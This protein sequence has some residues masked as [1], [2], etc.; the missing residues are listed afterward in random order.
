MPTGTLRV[1]LLW[2]MHQPYYKNLVTGEYRLPWVRLHASKDYYGMVKLLDEFPQVHQNFNLVPSLIAQIE[3]YASGVFREPFYEVAAKPASELSP[4]EKRFALS[5]LFQANVSQM[6]GRYPRFRDLYERFKGAGEDPARAESSFTTRDYTDLQVL[7]QLAWL[8]EFWLA[9]PDVKELVNKREGY[10]AQDQKFVLQ[11]QREIIRAVLPAYRDAAARGSIEISPTPYYHPILPL[12]CDTNVGA[13]SSPGLP[14]PQNRFEHPDDADE[15]IRR[16]LNSH[17]KLFGVRPRG[18]WPSEGSVSEEV[19]AIASKNGLNWVATDEG[20]LGRSLDYN[21]NRDGDGRL[22]S[23]GAERLYKIYRYEKA[24]TKMHLVFRDHRISDLIGFVYANMAPRDA[25]S[26]LLRSLKQAAEPLLK[27]GSD[28]VVPIILDGENAWE[29]YHESGRDFLRY[30]YDSLSKDQGVQ[31]C[32]IS[33]AIA[34]SSPKQLGQLKSLVPGS[35]I[36][37]NFNVW[38]G[39][40]EDNRAW[41]YL[42]EA[43]EFYEEHADGATAEQRNLA[44]EELLIA[45][46]SDWNWWYGP[47]HHSANDRDFDDLYRA[48]LSNVYQALGGEPPDYLAQPIAAAGGRPTT[49]SQTAYISPRINGRVASY[50]DWMG[51]AMYAADRRTSS[52]HGKQFVLDA[53]YAGIND[54]S[55]SVRADLTQSL[56]AGS[57]EFRVNV[58]VERTNEKHGFRLD[59]I[60]TDG[61]MQRWSLIEENGAERQRAQSDGL[62]AGTQVAFQKILEAQIPF[63]LLGARANDRIKLRFSVWRDRL[64]IDALPLEGSVELAIVPEEAL[65]AGVYASR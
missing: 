14:L 12:V 16:A 51:A 20:V 58:D 32:T 56:E 4:E 40:K 61:K 9:Q 60:V 1:V 59:V 13:V 44:Y 33:E 7:S 23:D 21:F 45:E 15:Q 27:K 18:M 3:D 54:T 30:F 55:L 49:T 25:A 31:A 22:S 64:P 39:A 35:W 24:S 63:T 34:L 37:A 26:H 17:E 19:L 38:I 11:K 46:G 53:V 6:I 50:F 28:A 47:E 43:R 48:H 5:Y 36:N 42:A 41:D 10:T 57:L 2:H 62:T 29:G 52:M 8:D 65:A